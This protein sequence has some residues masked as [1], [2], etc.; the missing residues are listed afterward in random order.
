MQVEVSA[1]AAEDSRSVAVKGA[2][3]VLPVAA[4]VAVDAETFEVAAVGVLL[5]GLVREVRAA[6][7]LAEEAG[8]EM[9]L[10]PKTS[11]RLALS[12]VAFAHAALLA[13]GMEA[14]MSSLVVAVADPGD[15]PG[16]A[17]AQFEGCR[18]AD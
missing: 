16:A 11:Y 10:A 8:A 15:Q 5:G 2:V 18:R 1:E 4:D 14:G 12:L 17:S 3:M 9:L 13:E 6:C 7:S